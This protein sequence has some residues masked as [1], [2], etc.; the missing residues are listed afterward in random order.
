MR[1]R[2]IAYVYILFPADCVN[3]VNRK[4]TALK[5]IACA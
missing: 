3:S 1:A 5:S 4:I 2:R